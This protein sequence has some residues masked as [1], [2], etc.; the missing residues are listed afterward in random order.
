MPLTVATTSVPVS[1][2]PAPIAVV[3]V[4]VGVAVSLR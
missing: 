1:R 4:P 3:N 2:V